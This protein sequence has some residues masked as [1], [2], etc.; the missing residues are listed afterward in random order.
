MN[1]KFNLKHQ[2]IYLSEVNQIFVWPQG[3]GVSPY[4]QPGRKNTVLFTTS[5]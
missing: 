1:S 3:G 5:L 2:S 4:G